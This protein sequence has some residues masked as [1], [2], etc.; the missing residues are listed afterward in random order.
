M[1]AY[2]LLPP[3]EDRDLVFGAMTLSLLLVSVVATVRPRIFGSGA[4][5]LVMATLFNGFIISAECHWSPSYPL[6]PFEVLL[7]QAIFWIPFLN[8]VILAALTVRSLRRNSATRSALVWTW[9]VVTPLL[10]MWM[11]TCVYPRSTAQAFSCRNRLQDVGIAQLCDIETR[12]GPFLANRGGREGEPARSWRV[13]LLP[14]LK[15]MPL[16]Q[17]YFDN[18]PWDSAENLPAAIAAS[19]PYSCP[20]NFPASDDRGRRYSVYLA[21]IGPG[22][23]FPTQDG[24]R[25]LDDIPDGRS[26][27]AMIVEACGRNV[28]WTEPRDLDVSSASTGI[29]LPGTNPGESDGLLSSRHPFGTSVLMAD[30]TVKTF[31]PETS[32]DVLRAILTVDGNEKTPFE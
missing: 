17:Q 29:N 25:A 21:C 24:E 13:D 27:T 30:S 22:A 4:L 11:G 31:G 32:P 3:F 9:S 1:Y 15:Q 6:R 10:V 20:V 26:Q 5:W 28:V 18:Q 14:C 16:R 8:A 7:H 23:F 12:N 2:P 19:I